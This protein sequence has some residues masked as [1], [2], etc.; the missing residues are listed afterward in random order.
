MRTF[1]TVLAWAGLAGTEVSRGATAVLNISC[2]YLLDDSGT[3]VADRVAVDALCVL[4]ADLA[5]DGFDA[6]GNGWVGDDDVLVV[7][8]DSEYP[9]SLAGGGTRAFD[10][11][12]GVTEAGF[13]T[14]SL[15]VDLTQFAGRSAPVPVALRWFPG[16][17]AAAVEVTAGGPPAGTA[18]GEFSR[19]VPAYPE[20]G[21]TAWV[22]PMGG[23]GENV[24]LDPL[25]TAELGGTDAAVLGTA[26]R[27]TGTS[28]VGT[29]LSGLVLTLNPGGT[30]SLRFSGGAGLKYKVQRS[31]DLTSW[32]VEWR[33]TAD[34]QGTGLFTDASPPAGRAFYR[35]SGPETP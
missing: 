24:T 19:M 31:T 13:F 3:A 10:L 11:A 2:G 1:L 26:S 18:Y 5:G 25:A 7:V 33:V 9:V 32:L 34:T 28:G 8:S 23:G 14:R 22:I 12:S 17:K 35:V 4:V 29:P 20:S 16:L 21:G 6:P 15:V 27:R 30:V